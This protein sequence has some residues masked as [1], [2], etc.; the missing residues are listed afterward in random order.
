MSDENERPDPVRQLCAALFGPDFEGDDTLYTGLDSE[1]A[2]DTIAAAL[3]EAAARALEEAAEEMQTTAALRAGI[4]ERYAKMMGSE[5]GHIADGAANE[6]YGKALRWL[7]A[8]A[9]SIRDEPPS[10]PT[11]P[12]KPRPP[13]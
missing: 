2:F 10:W 13:G 6:L 12:D 7:R 3:R 1:K 9:T 5:V 8:R 4:R 11:K